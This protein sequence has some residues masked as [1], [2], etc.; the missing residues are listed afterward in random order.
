MQ[1]TNP[2]QNYHPL[3]RNSVQFRIPDK[4]V[5]IG[6]YFT[7]QIHLRHLLKKHFEEYCKEKSILE[8]IDAYVWLD[9]ES[10]KADARFSFRLSDIPRLARWYYE[11]KTYVVLKSSL[12][13]TCKTFTGPY[14]YWVEKKEKKDSNRLVFRKFSL[15][16]DLYADNQLIYISIV[17]DGISTVLKKNVN[18]LIAQHQMDTVLLN[19][20]IYE[21]ECLPYWSS[22]SEE[23][24]LQNDKVYPILRRDIATLMQMEWE[25]HID[26]YKL[27]TAFKQI[28]LFYQEQ[29][30]TDPVQPIFPE[31]PEWVKVE[32]DAVAELKEKAK[33]LSF[34][35]GHAS[36]DIYQAFGKYGPSRLP[37]ARHYKVFIISLKNA[38]V[39]KQTLENHL[40]AK[41][42]FTSLQEYSHLPLVYSP[43]LNIEISDPKHM[44]QAVEEGI[45][46]MEKETG[47]ANFA[48]YISPYP[49]YGQ[50]KADEKLYY[51]IKEILLKRSIFSQAMVGQSLPANLNLWIPNIAFSMVAKMGGI[52]W[53]LARNTEK[54]LIVGF[55]AY[56]IGNRKKPYVGSAF[57]FDN[58][59]L[60]QEFDCWHET[61]EWAFNGQLY[62]A[63]LNY[64]ARNKGIK[65]IVIHYYKELN[66]KEFK[67]VVELLDRFEI[68]IPL[69]VV[70]INSSFNS[71]ELVIDTE[72]P[73]N[74][75]L[76]ATYYHLCYQ[77]YLLYINEREE[78]KNTDVKK[79]GYPLKVSLQSNR[80]GLFEDKEIVRNHSPNP[81]F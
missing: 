51:R 78:G 11:F 80:A 68:D 22:S 46:A 31:K 55:G 74:I 2:M 81:A 79:A 44:E 47:V 53:K 43:R 17:W 12:R 34:G 77:D 66:K 72:H 57:C 4:E 14:Q 20:V 18:A 6:L 13:I 56:R 27:Q 33:I 28:R 38:E 63:I 36:A 75:P 65:R 58:E 71:K 35:R 69:I 54:E 61:H 42:G 70:R 45:R 30:L 15:Y 73:R 39:A 67:V 25:N 3:I 32:K 5:E 64:K 49:K 40:L 59:G 16:F 41:Q 52:P 9:V 29:L 7:E 8:R 60:F 62:K 23:M 24:R 37:E 10:T 21:K 48:F 1:A 26:N 50:A 76:N 19:A